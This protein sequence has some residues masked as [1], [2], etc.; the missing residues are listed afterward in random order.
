MLEAMVDC[1]PRWAIVACFE[2]WGS[3]G[4][5]SWRGDFPWLPLGCS[6]ASFAASYRFATS[7]VPSFAGGPG[8]AV[9]FQIDIRLSLVVL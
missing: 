6:F 8:A 2:N 3:F 4:P 5:S 1:W 9:T 7:S